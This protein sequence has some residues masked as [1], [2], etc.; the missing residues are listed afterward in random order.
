MGA[1]LKN[2][3]KFR[4]F[5]RISSRLADVD[6]FFYSALPWDKKAGLILPAMG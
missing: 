4:E 2:R 3:G 1:N 6:K 5:P